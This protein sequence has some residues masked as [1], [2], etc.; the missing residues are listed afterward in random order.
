[1]NPRNLWGVMKKET[2]ENLDDL[3]A[4]R[5]MLCE[6]DRYHSLATRPCLELEVSEDWE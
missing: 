6:G 4:R 5:L 2:T 3:V 1:M